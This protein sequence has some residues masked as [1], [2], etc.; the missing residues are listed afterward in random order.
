MSS[1]SRP[2]NTEISERFGQTIPQLLPVGQFT[3]VSFPYQR[4]A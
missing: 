2:L 1:K 3:D 4:N